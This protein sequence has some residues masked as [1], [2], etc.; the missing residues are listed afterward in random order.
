MTDRPAR[1]I[2]PVMLALFAAVGALMGDRALP[3]GLTVTAA[4]AG[5]AALVAWRGLVSWPLAIALLAT[6]AGLV[7][8]GH[9]NSANLAWMGFCVIAGWVALTSALPVTV[10]TGGALGLGIAAEWLQQRDEPGWTAWV[11]GTAFT[12]VACVFAHRLRETVVQLE[13]AQHQLAER[14]RA[15]ERS[16][17]AGEVH[18]VIGHALTVSLLHISSARLAL[19]EDPDEA[20]QALEEA[21]R[22][23]RTSLEE[24]RAT[25]GL[26][27]T[28]ASGETAPMPGAA[29]IPAL[30]ES[31][32]RA[33]VEV[34]LDLDG[35]LTT[36]GPA[37]GLAAYRIVQE[38]L[39]N[40][41]KHAPGEPVTVAGGDSGGV[42]TIVV[43]N[44]GV[45]RPGAGAGMG[46][47]GMQERA[48]A[49]GG[50]LVAGPH[51]EG[52]TVRARMPR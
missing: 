30:V 26:M 28:D 17:I 45:P 50:E 37:R 42:V 2:A 12:L 13:A 1:V 46:I 11:V 31:F 22:L 27:R 33:G 10:V 19:D 48:S 25:V 5:L 20:R 36:L 7:V 47:R 49:V 35:G 16:R 32:R 44:G 6:A 29:D 9:G 21:E 4:I 43:R 15:E 34:D 24:V 52:W 41:T 38:A 40:A 18:D 23:A 51:D 39:T 14:S 3:L 8:L